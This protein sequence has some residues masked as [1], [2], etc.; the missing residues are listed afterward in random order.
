MSL[1]AL[2]RGKELNNVVMP[3]VQITQKVKLVTPEFYVQMT[4]QIV[5]TGLNGQI[6]V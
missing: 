2:E 4:V 3:V 1:V 6:A 5:K